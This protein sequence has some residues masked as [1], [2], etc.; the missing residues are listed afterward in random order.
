MS[1]GAKPGWA[2]GQRKEQRIAGCKPVT[3]MG[4][5]AFGNPFLQ[6]TFTIEI[7]SR[8]ARLRG[9]PPLLV[10]SELLLESEGKRARYRVVWIGEKDSN[11]E[12]HVGLEC[13]DSNPSIFGIDPPPLGHFYDEYKRVEAE[14]HRA[15]DRYKALFD[16]SL[17][18]IC[19]HD[20]KGVLLS[21][22]P[23]AAE[24]LGYDMQSCP[25]PHLSDFLS[26]A[27]RPGFPAYLSRLETHGQDSGYMH[28]VA[29]DRS[30][31]VWQYRNLVIRENGKPAY[32]LGHAMD[33]TE[34]KKVE[35][36]L[37]ETLNSLQKALAEVRTLKGLLPICAWCKRIRGDEG[38][39]H[40]LEDYV[41]EHSD[42][43]FSHSIC[44]GCVPK[45]Q[46]GSE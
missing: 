24:A 43:S 7:A 8:G 38:E 36:E 32:V 40:S 14:L 20:M 46:S 2:K 11:Y 12:G 33:V 3:V 21:I 44:P 18:L 16:H 19:T 1:A 29:R 5:D 26:P 31:R 37:Q 23:A 41:S 4:Q 34:Q 25:R 28:V 30:T 22:N 9:L 6:N 17:G 39:W 42:A 35:R 13:I 45:L 27:A 10:H 15:Q